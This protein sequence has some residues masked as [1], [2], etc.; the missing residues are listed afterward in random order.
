MPVGNLR[1]MQVLQDTQVS[2]ITSCPGQM[3][4]IFWLI[5]EE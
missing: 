1:Y 2:L 3:R 4:R 5:L